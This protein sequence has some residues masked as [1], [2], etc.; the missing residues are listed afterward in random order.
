MNRVAENCAGKSSPAP[1]PSLSDQPDA[2]LYVWRYSCHVLDTLGE[3]SEQIA[4]VRLALVQAVNPV[5]K[6]GLIVLTSKRV[7]AC[8]YEVVRFQF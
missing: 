1:H 6:A 3:E 8:P 7:L 4:T 5:V 2:I